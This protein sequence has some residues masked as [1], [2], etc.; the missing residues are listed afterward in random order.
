[1]AQC[2]TVYEAKTHLSGP[3]DRAATGEEIVIPRNGVPQ[4][5]LVLL[6]VRGERRK[7]ADDRASAVSRPISAPP[8]PPP[9]PCP[10]PGQQCTRYPT[11]VR[12]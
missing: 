3:I 4:T 6:A 12:L 8:T 1:M 9:R 10:P 7:P 5:R 2:V 11:P